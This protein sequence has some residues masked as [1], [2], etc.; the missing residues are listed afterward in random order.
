MKKTILLFAIALTISCKNKT[1]NNKNQPKDSSSIETIIK[2]QE[3]PV[4]EA[5]V[6]EFSLWRHAQTNTDKVQD[7]FDQNAVYKVSRSDTDKPGYLSIDNIEIYNGS[8]YQI[9]AVVKKGDV[10]SAFGLRIQS[11][12]PNRI[13]AIFDL[14]RGEVVSS[15]VTGAELADAADTS[16]EKLES[17]WFKCSLRTVFKADQ[18]RV[19]MGPTDRLKKSQSWESATGDKNNILIAPKALKI[20]EY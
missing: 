20:L 19:I 10:G 16:I 17:G 11:V 12:Y 13:D 7:T 3:K 14:E 15:S 8:E 5:S 18:I 2:Q 4:S 9:S 1:E 6:P